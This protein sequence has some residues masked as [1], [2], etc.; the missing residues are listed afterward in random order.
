MK[1]KQTLQIERQQQRLN[2]I[3]DFNL[4]KPE[5]GSIIVD[6]LSNTIFR[7]LEIK[8]TSY[9]SMSVLKKGEFYGKFHTK[10]LWDYYDD[11]IDE[12]IKCDF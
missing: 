11:L 12:P 3:K 8:G 7:Y 6:T 5:S 2:N 9:F 10:I 1:D 4:E